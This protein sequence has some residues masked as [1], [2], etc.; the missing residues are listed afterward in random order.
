MDVKP[1]PSEIMR[2]QYWKPLECGAIKEPHG[3][4]KF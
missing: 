4:K 1:V 3:W 2:E